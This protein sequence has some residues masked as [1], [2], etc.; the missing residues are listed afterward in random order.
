MKFQGLIVSLFLGASFLLTTGCNAPDE[1]ASAAAATGATIPSLIPTT[2]PVC[3][4]QPLLTVT[5]NSGES[6]A[7]K[8]WD[9]NNTIVLNYVL[10]ESEEQTNHIA[11]GAG[12][13]TVTA[14]GA[15]S[16][17]T[18]LAAVQKMNCGASYG[19]SFEDVS[20]PAPQDSLVYITN[21]FTAPSYI[22][23][24]TDIVAYGSLIAGGA[25]ISTQFAP[26]THTIKVY[27]ST[28]T[29]Q[30]Y[31]ITFSTLV[32]GGFYHFV[33]N[34]SL[35]VIE[36]HNNLNL[37]SS[38]EAVKV[39]VDNTQINF[40]GF[41]SIAPGAIGSITLSHTGEFN[42]RVVGAT[43]GTTYVDLQ[44]ANY[45]DGSTSTINVNP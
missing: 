39:F 16:N 11:A 37:G 35:P 38:P 7:V 33:T 17:T 42:I 19:L 13:Y 14:V 22:L 34:N 26:G 41:S 5:N 30:L 44:N 8:V 21:A 9:K 43:S 10:D 25:T 4:T 6:A 23:L 2:A 31:G 15:S 1:T 40:N 24:D 18:L 3:A 27:D 45:N 28:G 29:H 20:A 32:F 12:T 36:F